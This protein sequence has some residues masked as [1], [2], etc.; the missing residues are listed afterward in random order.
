MIDKGKVSLLG[1]KDVYANVIDTSDLA[2][3]I[4]ENFQSG[5]SARIW[6]VKTAMGN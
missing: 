1:K 2:R 6:S 3:Y 5:R 4:V